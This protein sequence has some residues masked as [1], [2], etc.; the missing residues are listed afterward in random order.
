MLS[1]WYTEILG[2]TRNRTHT[3]HISSRYDAVHFTDSTLL[4]FTFVPS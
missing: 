4:T 1:E 3:S 2:C